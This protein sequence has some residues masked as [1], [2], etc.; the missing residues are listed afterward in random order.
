MVLKRPWPEWCGCLNRFRDP[1]CGSGKSG[2]TEEAKRLIPKI[3]QCGIGLS[4]ARIRTAGCKR[5]NQTGPPIECGKV[6]IYRHCEPSEVW[7]AE[8]LLRAAGRRKR[9][10]KSYSNVQDCLVILHD[11]QALLDPFFRKSDRAALLD[12][13]LGPQI[14]RT[15]RSARPRLR[16]SELLERRAPAD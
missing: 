4:A 8:R 14:D 16:R 15:R 5:R 7:S 10:S 2:N 1:L 11:K 3:S 6:G 12:Y 13:L 9:C